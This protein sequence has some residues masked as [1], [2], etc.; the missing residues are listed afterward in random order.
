MENS[1]VL[2]PYLAQNIKIRIPMGCVSLAC[3]LL[4][5]WSANQHCDGLYL[6]IIVLARW[7]SSFAV[8]A[9]SELPFCGLVVSVGF[10]SLYRCQAVKFWL[11][12]A[13]KQTA[14]AILWVGNCRFRHKPRICWDKVALELYLSPQLSAATPVNIT[15]FQKQPIRCIVMWLVQNPVWNLPC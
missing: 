6:N 7:Q 8:V 9:Y 3:V 11:L 13:Q 4:S 14:R 15:I 12:V 1:H 2:T 10:I 5:E